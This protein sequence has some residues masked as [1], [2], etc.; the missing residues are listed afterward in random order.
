MNILKFKKKSD[1]Q[2]Q[3]DQ[4]GQD[5]L[6]QT[7]NACIKCVVDAREEFKNNKIEVKN[8]EELRNGNFVEILNNY[9]KAE[10]DKSATAKD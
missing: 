2:I 10:Y 8:L 6:A 9:A 3:Y 1:L 4:Q 7:V 5:V